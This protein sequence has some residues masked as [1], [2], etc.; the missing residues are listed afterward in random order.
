MSLKQPS[1]IVF[2]YHEVGVR[3]LRAL[4]AR[5]VHVSLVVTHDND[6]S[7]T[8]WFASMQ[9]ECRAH[10][11]PF[12]MPLNPRSDD[13]LFK[14]QELQPDFIFS[15]YYRFMLPT[16]VLEQ[17]RCGSFNMHGSLLPKYRGRA[18]VNW[19]VLHGETETGVTLHEM[20]AKPDAG[21]IV[22]QSAVPIFPDETAFEVMQK[23]SVVAEQT[24]WTILPDLLQM[25][26]TRLPNQLSRGS[27][28]GG[29]KPEDGLV[30]WSKPA[31]E[32]YNLHR[33]VA[34]PYPGAWTILGEHKLTIGKAHLSQ[35]VKRSMPTGLTVC[36]NE[37]I[38]VCGD[39][40]YIVISQLL[41]NSQSVSPRYLAELLQGSGHHVTVPNGYSAP[42]K[43]LF[44]LGINGFIGHHLCKRILETTDWKICG[45]DIESH[46]IS[47]FLNC[48]A[49]KQRMNFKQGD[50]E[51]NWEWVQARIHECDAI[52]PLA[53][54]ATPL[55][56]V[57]TPL[58]V[59]EL[60][61]ESNVRIV[62]LVADAKKR[63]IF[64]S[65]SEVYG[66]CRDEEFDT[67]TSELVCGPIKASR[68]IY[69]CSKQ[70]LDRIIFA[71]GDESL[72]FT[73]FRPFNC[74][75]LGLDSVEA[76]GAGKS[77]VTTQFIGN[78]VRNED[79]I[80]VDGG[81]QSRTFIYVDDLIDALMK[82]IDNKDGIASGK[83][84]NIGNPANNCTIRQLADLMLKEAKSSDKLAQSSSKI[85]SATGV[86]YYGE[87]YQ[88]MH[89]RVPNISRTMTD[90]DWKPSVSLEDAIHELFVDLI[91]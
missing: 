3:C 64:P 32:V 5:G 66:M 75:G 39:G 76:I 46:R 60:D 72:D 34:P 77:R 15:F 78:I 51:T 6:P 63:L 17:A 47:K 16:N 74:I 18:P 87:G 71:Y 40:R 49:Y 27:Y 83:I 82:I 84:Y 19:A 24:L 11:I 86:E 69:S 30:D 33:A 70:L 37:I 1:A 12:I 28:F 14:V 52:L 45:I 13:L 58:R 54:L 31:Q 10:D 9:E 88:D 65:T 89:R 23:I 41:K 43:C 79:I 57:K 62:R 4:L 2:G 20:V 53:A 44:I 81:S 35:Q 36:D 25:E 7:E 56:Y 90:L 29:R 80:L 8:I 48:V 91:T 26:A 73:I 22:A 59:F 55:S 50:I 38:G 85:R 61:F 42:P 21:P 67:E 68:W